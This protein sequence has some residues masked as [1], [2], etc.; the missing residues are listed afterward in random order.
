MQLRV[1][2]RSSHLIEEFTHGNGK[3]IAASELNDLAG[4]A[5]RG[6]HNDGLV[7]K[8]LVV[9]ENA[10]DA[11]NARVLLLGVL[12]LGGGLVPVK[13]AAD[14]GGDEESTG[15]GSGDG[16]DERE[17]ESQI[18][19]DAMVPLEDLG[20]LNALPCGSNLDQN[21]VLGDALLLVELIDR[22]CTCQWTTYPKESWERM[23]SIPE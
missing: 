10:L 21:T 1:G 18:G 15:L 12:P 5:E 7:A 13:D 4:V 2:W 17:H 11:S 23:G 14:E 8:F 16:L 3:I 19:I 9:V 6:T 20:G 22:K